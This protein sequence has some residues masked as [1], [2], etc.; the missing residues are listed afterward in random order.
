ML[1]LLIYLWKPWRNAAHVDAQISVC[2][3]KL[4]DRISNSLPRKPAT[5][6]IP[7]RRGDRL[8]NL[9]LHHET[10]ITRKHC[11]HRK[12]CKSR[13]TPKRRCNCDVRILTPITTPAIRTVLARYLPP[14]PAPRPR[15]APPASSRSPHPRNPSAAS[16]TSCPSWQPERC[17]SP[18]R[19]SSSRR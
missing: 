15:P 16:R 17:T 7:I 12:S 11:L 19:V 1:S 9:S 13:S 4:F 5:A 6:Y 18:P 2:W 8:L 14:A 10:P 3:I